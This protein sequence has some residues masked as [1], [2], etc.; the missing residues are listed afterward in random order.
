MKVNLYTTNQLA[1]KLGLSVTTIRN[2]FRSGRIKGIKVGT[3][4]AIPDEEVTRL[5]KLDRRPGQIR[6]K[7]EER[8]AVDEDRTE[9]I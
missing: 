2:Y 3:T 8:K 6:W 4:I 9:K 7:D 1:E 5:K